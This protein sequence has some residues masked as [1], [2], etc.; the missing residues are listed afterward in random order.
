MDTAPVVLC[1][2]SDGDKVRET[3]LQVMKR[4][5]E[6]VPTP[7]PTDE[8]GSAV[9]DKLGLRKWRKFESDAVM[10][11]IYVRENGIEFFST[12]EAVSGEWKMAAG[13]HI[14]L[15][16]ETEHSRV[17]DIIMHTLSEAKETERASGG[18]LMLL[19]PP[20]QE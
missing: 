8:A 6:V 19:P 9:L 1:D 20:A 2:I 16:A 3:L 15:P 13:T 4:T 18:G 12:G 17:V 10:F 7:A 5:N 11:N 14:N